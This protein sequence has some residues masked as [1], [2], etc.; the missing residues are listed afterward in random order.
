MYVSIRSDPIVAPKKWLDPIRSDPTQNVSKKVRSDPIRS[1]APQKK[2]RPDPITSYMAK[3]LDP[4]RSGSRYL[5]RIEKLYIY[6]YIYIHTCTYTQGKSHL[7]QYILPINFELIHIL[8]LKY[9]KR[10]VA[11]L[12]YITN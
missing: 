3:N 5:D 12:L 11:N 7:L 9:N 10:F 4:T 6:I 1:Q 2:V 8:H